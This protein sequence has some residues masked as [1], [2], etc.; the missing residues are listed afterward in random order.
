MWFSARPPVKRKI[1]AIKTAHPQGH[2][3]FLSMRCFPK[4]ALPGL[5]HLLPELKQVGT[6]RRAVPDQSPLPRAP[7][8]STDLPAIAQPL[9]YSFDSCAFGFIRGCPPFS[10]PF[11]ISPDW[12]TRECPSNLR[13]ARYLL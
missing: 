11:P 10:F 7:F 4:P 13:Q 5:D 8:F 2:A 12:P 1:G 3:T 6:D 9:S